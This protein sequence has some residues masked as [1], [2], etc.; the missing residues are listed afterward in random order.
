M[1]IRSTWWSDVQGIIIKRKAVEDSMQFYFCFINSSHFDQSIHASLSSEYIFLDYNF[2]L[3][4][5]N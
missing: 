5:L 4:M 1:M 3:F 2:P